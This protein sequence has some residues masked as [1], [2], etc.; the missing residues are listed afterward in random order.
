MMG[1]AERFSGSV[2]ACHRHLHQG[3]GHPGDQRLQTH[4][5]VDSRVSGGVSVHPAQGEDQAQ[6]V[7]L[8]EDHGVG[9]DVCVVVFRYKALEQKQRYDLLS[10]GEFDAIQKQ[11]ESLYKIIQIDVRSGA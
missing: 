6:Q 2:H 9:E 4:R 8:G 10:E 7:V 3:D 5:G 11:V 1:Y